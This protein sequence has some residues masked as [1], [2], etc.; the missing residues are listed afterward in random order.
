MA[1]RAGDAQALRHMADEA[2]WLG[3]GFANLLYLYSPDAIIV[4][5]GVA[6]ALDLMRTDIEATLRA[7]AMPAYQ[8]VP[9]VRARLGQDAGLIGAASL[10]WA[11]PTT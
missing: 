9:V 2:R 6:E 11:T 1:A 7:Q 10:V 8:D 4:G 3:L 5:G